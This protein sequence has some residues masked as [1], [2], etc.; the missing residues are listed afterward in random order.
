MNNTGFCFAILRWDP[1]ASRD[2]P[3]SFDPS[4][5]R[6][7]EPTFSRKNVLEFLDRSSSSD[8]SDAA[9]KALAFAIAATYS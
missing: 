2:L 6:M 1:S 3:L 5:L 8:F 9:S 4:G 7:L